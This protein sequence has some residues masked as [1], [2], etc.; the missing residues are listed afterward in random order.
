MLHVLTLGLLML[1]VSVTSTPADTLTEVD[2]LRIEN[3]R[4]QEQLAAAYADG[5]GCRVAL[6]PYRRQENV[7]AVQKAK[8]ALKAQIEA[9]HDGHAYNIEAGTLERRPAG[10]VP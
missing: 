2:R 7:L 5:D 8:A 3:V 4:L 9:A 1:Q 10:T 6:A